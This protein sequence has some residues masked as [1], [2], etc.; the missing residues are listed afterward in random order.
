[1]SR[2]TKAVN[3]V[4]EKYKSDPFFKKVLDSQRE[5]ADLIRPWWTASLKSSVF[6]ME[7]GAKK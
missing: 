6:L 4:L 3:E 5:Y 1:M 2:Y 7:V